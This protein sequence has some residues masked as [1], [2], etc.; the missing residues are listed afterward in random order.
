MDEGGVSWSL[1]AQRLHL[2]LHMVRPRS[3]HPRACL[4]VAEKYLPHPFR[5][6]KLAWNLHYSVAETKWRRS[7]CKK[8]GMSG[9]QAKTIVVPV[10]FSRELLAALG[11]ALE[12]AHRSLD[13]EIDTCLTSIRTIRKY[14]QVR[15]ALNSLGQIGTADAGFRDPLAFS[16][17]P[18][19]AEGEL[20]ITD[21][22]QRLRLSEQLVSEILLVS[23]GPCH[24]AL[25]SMLLD[26]CGLAESS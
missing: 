20:P 24:C 4:C 3:A 25:R 10:D 7:P 13:M 14:R 21:L 9:Y 16:V 19:G 26:A 18:T 17:D 12:I 2:E 5:R 22:A 8:S 23:D 6:K 15:F 11:T 1:Q